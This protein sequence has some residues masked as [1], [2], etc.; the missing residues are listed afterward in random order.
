M[1]DLRKWKALVENASK[2][3]EDPV[4]DADYTDHEV[5][6]AKSQ[7]LSSMKSINRIAKH[8]ATKSE[9]E[10]LEGWTASKLTM[11]EDYLQVVADYF[12][13]QEINEGYKVLP[14][15]DKEKYQA[16]D[17]LEGPFSTLSGK[18]VYYDP[19]AGKYYD[20]D[21]DMYMSYDEFRRY[22]DDYKGMK[23]ERDEVNEAH[24]IDWPD[25]DEDGDSEMEQHAYNAIRHGMHAYDAYDHV[26]SMSRE[27]D[28]LSANKDDIIKM[29]AKYGLQTESL[30]EAKL[31]PEQREELDDLIDMVKWGTSPSTYDPDASD[32]AM[33]ALKIIR[34]KFGD[35][36]ADQVA[37]GI[38]DFHFPRHG[39]H[40]GTYGTDRLA[41]KKPTQIKKDGKI[42]ARSAKSTKRD[43]KSNLRGMGKKDPK[44]L[45]EQQAIT[46]AEFDE[47]AGEKDACYHKVKSRY[48]VWPSAYASGALVKC[49]KVGAKNWGNSKKD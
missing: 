43:I 7:M 21:T 26:Y 23:D 15:I 36:V 49:R 19:K 39:M 20:P 6:M 9:S 47:A 32:D 22:D 44:R 28:W 40:P 29:F 46:E 45:G 25:K 17:G 16:R 30:E 10:G 4:Q 27:R 2:L 37:D 48:K 14:P 18:V 35:K 24:Q 13:G 5:S 41:S 3:V 33:K 11:A 34:S 42:D 12:D 31:S 1:S 8:L 38:H